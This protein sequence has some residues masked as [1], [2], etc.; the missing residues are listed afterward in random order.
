MLLL[1]RD[2]CV[3]L[4]PVDLYISELGGSSAIF[5]KALA[6]A[7]D[8]TSTAKDWYIMLA[9]S[10]ERDDN[11]IFHMSVIRLCDP[12]RGR[13]CPSSSPRESRRKETRSLLRANTSPRN[14]TRERVKY[15]LED[16]VQ[17]GEWKDADPRMHPVT[18]LDRRFFWKIS[19]RRGNCSRE[20]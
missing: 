12:S 11:V 6:P 8:S 19:I 16:E 1:R 10:Y 7:L 13:V 20:R 2:R 17:E 15:R 5:W 18:L 4:R 3:D 9:R 14:A